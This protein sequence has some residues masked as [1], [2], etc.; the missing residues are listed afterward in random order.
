MLKLIATRV[1]NQKYS[2]KL[3]DDEEPV[4][5]ILDMTKVMKDLKDLDMDVLRLKKLL[6]EA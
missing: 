4:R 3:I 1:E 2:L 6:N 5:L